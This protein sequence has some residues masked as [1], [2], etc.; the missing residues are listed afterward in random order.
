MLMMLPVMTSTDQGSMLSGRE[1]RRAGHLTYGTADT[2]TS[3]EANPG[4]EAQTCRT[5][6]HR[7]G[8]AE[9]Q[10][11]CPNAEFDS[12]HSAAAHAVNFF[13]GEIAHFC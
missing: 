4:S 7:S 1:E 11:C 2:K 8:S 12:I 6:D 9:E 3:T 10:G 13:H 5:P